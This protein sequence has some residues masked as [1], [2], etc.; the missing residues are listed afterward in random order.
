MPDAPAVL[1]A[2]LTAGNG[3]DTSSAGGDVGTLTAGH[4]VATSGGRLSAADMAAV[5]MPDCDLNT[6]G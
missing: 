3:G 4:D 2:V 6:S 1:T 5:L